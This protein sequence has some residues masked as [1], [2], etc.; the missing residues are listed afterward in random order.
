MTI[1]SHTSGRPFPSLGD[2][3][4][5]LNLNSKYNIIYTPVGLVIVTNHLKSKASIYEEGCQEYKSKSNE[6]N[7][8]IDEKINQFI[9][10]SEKELFPD[11]YVKNKKKEFVRKNADRFTNQLDELI[12]NEILEIEFIGP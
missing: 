3:N 12:G 8:D 5:I 10:E 6:I 1:H 7:N 2:L 4:T 11:K 9:D